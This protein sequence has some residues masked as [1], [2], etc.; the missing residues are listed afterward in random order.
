MPQ[1]ICSV[2]NCG[3]QARALG[4]CT[5]HYQR[6]KRTGDVGTDAPLQVR[7]LC[8][9]PDCG[10]PHHARGLCRPHYYQARNRALRAP[11][12]SQSDYIQQ[13]IRVDDAGCWNWTMSLASTGYGFAN[14]MGLRTMAHRF[15][16]E[17][18]VGRIPNGLHIDHLCR[19]RACVNPDHLEPV[20]PGENIRR[21][22]A[23]AAIVAR[24]GICL[25]GHKVSGDNVYVSP[26]STRRCR[27]C[28]AI[29]RRQ[30]YDRERASA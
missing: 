30:R 14:W 2:E 23:P 7:G 5:R 22:M 24:T 28:M 6:L 9:L 20:T 27:A 4:L 17:A 26:S 16:Y 12:P 19:N 8:E 21:G 10:T 18:Y 3:A 25:R 13:R 11:Q 29:V 1:G 15:S